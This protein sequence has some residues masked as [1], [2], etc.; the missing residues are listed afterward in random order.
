MHACIQTSECLNMLFGAIRL[1]F[2][3]K[4]CA[5]PPGGSTRQKQHKRQQS[6]ARWTQDRQDETWTHST[7]VHFPYVGLEG[8]AA[9]R[10]CFCAK[11][12]AHRA[13]VSFPPGTAAVHLRTHSPTRRRWRHHSMSARTPSY[14]P[15]ARIA[16]H[17]TGRYASVV[18]EMASARLSRARRNQP[19][20]PPPHHQGRTRLQTLPK[21]HAMAL[22]TSAW[23]PGNSAVL[24]DEE[25]MRARVR[26]SSE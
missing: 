13:D 3:F 7:W 24:G 25:H 8:L 26:Q 20:A 10:V 12:I 14:R 1:K 19:A 9:I 16:R 17:R 5:M 2:K 4:W 23:S 15:A 11:T 21:T 18:S 22:C 6:L